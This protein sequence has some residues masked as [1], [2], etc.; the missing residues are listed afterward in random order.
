V[1]YRIEYSKEAIEH[2]RE[3]DAR[4]RTLIFDVVD[5]QLTYEPTLETLNRKLMRPNVLSVYE[6]RVQNLRVYFDVEESP[7][8]VV[9]IRAIGRKQ[10]NRV[11]IAGEEIKL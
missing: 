6:L 10:G 9:V 11:Y 2:L 5:K 7:E 8:K 1:C 4:Q 3:L